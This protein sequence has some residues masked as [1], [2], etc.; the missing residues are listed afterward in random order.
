LSVILD[1]YTV[2]LDLWI[3]DPRGRVIANGRSG[4]YKSTKGANVANQAWFRE[5]LATK[6]GTEFVATDISAVDQLSGA[7]V[8]IYSTAIRE[9]GRSNGKPLGVLGIFF[10]WEKQSQAVVDGVRLS[11]DERPRT[12][13]LMLDSAHRVIAASDGTELFQRCP[14][15]TNGQKMNAYVD[16]SGTLV[17]FA[18]GPGYETYEGLG[19]YGVLL[20]QP[21]T[22]KESE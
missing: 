16:N 4:K 17:G 19:W 9:D 6:D 11:A 5:A 3:A 8:P 21:S 20:Q 7:R 13:C 10:D 18:L 15:E 12:R 22:K 14:I 1:S 2:H